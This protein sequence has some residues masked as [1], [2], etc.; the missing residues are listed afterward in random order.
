[1]FKRI[2]TALIS[3][4]VV[5]GI[6]N[7]QVNKYA[8]GREYGY[9]LDEKVL[10]EASKSP[11]ACD[12]K[13]NSS[14]MFTYTEVY[15]E[16][17][18][19]DDIRLTIEWKKTSLGINPYVKH[20]GGTLLKEIGSAG[21]GYIRWDVVSTFASATGVKGTLFDCTVTDDGKKYYL[22]F[23]LFST[24]EDGKRQIVYVFSKT[25]DSKETEDLVRTAV[26]NIAGTVRPPAK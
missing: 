23:F 6:A 19:P 8:E 3:L 7:A 11:V 10:T 26:R 18:K 15:C 14:S 13:A 17:A 20:L 5:A 24:K 4:L 1:M 22:S 2:I 25:P 16:N 12:E 21:E 9:T